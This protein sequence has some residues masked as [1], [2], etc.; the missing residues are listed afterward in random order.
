MKRKFVALWEGSI[1]AY[2]RNTVSKNIWRFRGVYEFNDLMGEA[3]LVFEKVRCKYANKV[4]NPKWF[5]S[6]YKSALANRLHDV[7]KTIG[8]SGTVERVEDE[9]SEVID[10]GY[11]YHL[12]EQAPEEISSVLS[13]F[14]RAPQ[15]LLGS[16]FEAWRAKGGKKVHGNSFLNHVLGLQARDSLH[17]KT[18]NY[19][20]GVDGE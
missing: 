10:S 4:D 1:E 16:A 7:S 8:N 13:L 14:L 11:L 3:Y 20:K 5:M 19:I 2:S 6:L 9:P 17:S 15:E 12:I 18:V